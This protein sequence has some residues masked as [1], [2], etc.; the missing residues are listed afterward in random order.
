MNNEVKNNYLKSNNNLNNSIK[1]NKKQINIILKN[2]ISDEINGSKIATIK[3]NNFMNLNNFS[4]KII[5]TNSLNKNGNIKKFILNNINKINKLNNNCFSK[6]KIKNKSKE[7]VIN[8]KLFSPHYNKRYN[9]YFEENEKNK[10][11]YCNNKNL[12]N[13]KNEK[14]IEIRNINKNKTFPLNNQ[15]NIKLLNSIKDNPNLF[16]KAFSDKNNS[17]FIDI[18]NINI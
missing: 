3:N 6:Y 18:N 17:K 14:K 15:I 11:I 4:Q 1:I 12:V 13:N 10:E 8:K 16:S 7:K 9:H 2:S 5:N